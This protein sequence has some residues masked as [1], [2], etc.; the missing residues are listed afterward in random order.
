MQSWT[1]SLSWGPGRTPDGGH[2]SDATFESM[3]HPLRARAALGMS[4]GKA[5]SLIPHHSREARRL[6]GSLAPLKVVRREMH[7]QLDSAPKMPSRAMHT[8]WDTGV[9][10]R[11]A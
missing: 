10:P 1:A 6:L 11:P 3:Y 7:A 9:Y 5:R 8:I 4:G 2:G